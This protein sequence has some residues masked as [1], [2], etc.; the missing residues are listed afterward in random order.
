MDAQVTTH[1]SKRNA[2][3]SFTQEKNLLPSCLSTE[4]LFPPS[5][6]T[7]LP[8]DEIR[9]GISVKKYFH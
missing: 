3:A 7:P 6:Q 4:F 1:Q 2:E 5:L 9:S 8:S